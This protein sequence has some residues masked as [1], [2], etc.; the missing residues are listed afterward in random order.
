MVRIAILTVPFFLTDRHRHFADGMVSSIR[1]RHQIDR[2]AIINTVRSVDDR[3]WLKKRFDMVEDN[4]TNILARAWNRGIREGFRRGADYVLVTNLD[5][6]F[7]P[8]CIDNLVECATQERDALVWCSA[9][10]TNPLSFRAARL[11]PSVEQA[12][13]WSCFMVDKRLLDV[14]G[15]FDEMFVP[16][17]REDSDMAYRLAAL[18][19]SCVTCHA[20]LHLNFDRGTIKGLIDCESSDVPR[21]VQM[22]T[23]LR[24]QITRND[25]RYVRKWGGDPGEERFVVPYGK[26]DPPQ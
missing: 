25:E 2:L 8:L 15:E 22:L 9:P 23:A 26:S 12:L 16:A 11:R 18:G 21:F 10:W 5:I 17:Y 24:S 20:A 6:E 4:D 19:A 3:E 14:A 1:S 7:H 13:F